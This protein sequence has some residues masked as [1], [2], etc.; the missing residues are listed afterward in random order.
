MNAEPVRQGDVYLHPCQIPVDA[1]RVDPKNGLYVLAL[2]EQSGHAHVLEENHDVEVLTKDGVIYV[3]NRIG[4]MLKH[5]HLPT[6]QPTTDHG[7]DVVPPGERVL[8]IQHET[9][10]DGIVRPVT[11]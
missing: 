10:P 6:M 1:C 2:G 8:R 5:I 9:R 3:R 7:A 11:D 4:S